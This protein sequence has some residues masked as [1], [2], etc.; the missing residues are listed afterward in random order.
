MV[1][2]VVAPVVFCAK[3]AEILKNAKNTKISCF[4]SLIFFYNYLCIVKQIKIHVSLIV[5]WPKPELSGGWSP[6][7][8]GPMDPGVLDVSGKLLSL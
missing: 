1:V 8:F 5:A 4:Y 7:H 3:A 6:N 2:A